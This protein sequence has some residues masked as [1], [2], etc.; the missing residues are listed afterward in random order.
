MTSMDRG[1]KISGKDY[2][3]Y[4][5][6]LQ[7]IIMQSLKVIFYSNFRISLQVHFVFARL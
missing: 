7:K 4:L 5:F 2:L 1:R 6:C 3:S